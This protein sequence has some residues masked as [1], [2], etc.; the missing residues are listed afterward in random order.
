MTRI[1]PED[2]QLPPAAYNSLGL[3]A[4]L[5]LLQR[6]RKY[7]IL[8]LG[9]ALGANLEFW[10]R[11][12]CR[13]TVDDFYGD[14]RTRMASEPETLRESLIAE[15]L[16]FDDQTV[17]DVILAWDLFNYLDPDEIVPL[18]RQLSRWCR[19]GTVLFALIS[20]LP[21]IP[22]KP[23]LFRIL[24]RERMTCQMR[25]RETQPCERHQPRDLARLLAG[26]EVTCS[27]LLRN[28]SQ[29]YLFTYLGD[30]R[31]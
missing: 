4:L 2:L 11:F 10:S 29:E 19:R 16:P 6:D 27:F 18:V 30:S 20:S 26:F 7:H 12:L 17:F 5:R 1:R 14:Y 21:L 31:P 3:S 9:P 15:L 8:D 24:D 13:L 28:G 25:T 22:A 23:S